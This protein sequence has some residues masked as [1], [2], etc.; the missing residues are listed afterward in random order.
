MNKLIG[1]LLTAVTAIWLPAKCRA[2]CTGEVYKAKLNLSSA[3]QD[4]T[5]NG[6]DVIRKAKVTTKQL[7][8]VALGR[9]FAD[10]VPA[11]E[12]LA[13]IGY[14]HCDAPHRLVVWDTTSQTVLATI[15][16]EVEGGYAENS[17][18]GVSTELMEVQSVGGFN[19]GHLTVSS[20]Y[21]KNA[22]TGCVSSFS[23]KVTGLIN[24]TVEDDEGEIV[25]VDLLVLSGSLTAK[26]PP[27]GTFVER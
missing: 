21:K 12:V 7:I 13:L 5:D 15:G 10:P 18:A 27:I 8:N 2:Q 16:V 26:A 3:V 25:T 4:E 17:T 1:V 9:N 22:S 11:N 24:A 20:T 6:K 23:S 19:S 14:C